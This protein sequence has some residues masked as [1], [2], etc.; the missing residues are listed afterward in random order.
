MPT[1]PA[2]GEFFPF[3]Q[4]D[5]RHARG[6]FSSSRVPQHFRSRLPAG[7][8]DDEDLERRRLV[9]ILTRDGMLRF[10]TFEFN[11]GTDDLGKRHDAEYG[12][13]W[14]LGDVAEGK[15]IG[16]RVAESPK[17]PAWAALR[18]EIDRS[19]P[20]R[21]ARVCLRAALSRYVR[22]P[23]LEIRVRRDSRHLERYMQLRLLRREFPDDMLVERDFGMDAKERARLAAEAGDEASPGDPPAVRV[24]R[25]GAGKAA[26]TTVSYAGRGFTFMPGDRF[27]DAEFVRSANST[28]AA[29]QRHAASVPHERFVTVDL[30][31]AG[32]VPWAY[33]VGVFDVLADLGVKRLNLPSS[34][35]ERRL[36]LSDFDNHTLPP[37]PPAETMVDMCG[38][39]LEIQPLPEP[40]PTPDCRPVRRDAPPWWWLVLAGVLAAAVALW[41]APPHRRKPEPSIRG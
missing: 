30:D 21:E 5:A 39:V 10:M 27:D 3:D 11:I 31:D 25:A 23:A 22:V 8:A 13:A 34:P 26:T 9:V 41:G 2:S 36:R 18:A 17:R 29:F 28:W 19:A 40:L 7:R 32:E 4:P 6:M 14:I 24:T 16:G 1:Q 37:Y 33:I 38:M 35:P 12:F 15:V 20:W